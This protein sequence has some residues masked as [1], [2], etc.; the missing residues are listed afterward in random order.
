VTELQPPR[1]DPL[2]NL[3][4]ELGLRLADPGLGTRA[5]RLAEKHAADEQLALAAMLKLAEES[6][7]ALAETLATPERGQ[8]LVFCLG[9]SELVGTELGLAGPGWG[10]LFESACQESADSLLSQMRCDLAGFGDRGEATRALAAFKRAMFFR[11][12]VSD[13]THRIDVT[14]TMAAMSRLADE[15]IRAAF[16]A[17]RRS[18]GELARSAGDFCVLGMGKLGA[19]ELNLSSD[20]DL[21]YIFDA[22]ASSDGY[23]AAARIG[24]IMTEML[25]TG[26]FRVDL[27]LR[28]GGRNSPLVIPFGGALS[29]Y[30]NMGQTWERAALLRARPVAGALD[31]GNRL[32][33][34]LRAF[35]YRRYLDFDTLRQLRAM[36]RQVEA[37]LRSLDLLRRNIKLGYG[38]IRELEFIVQALT[39]IYGGRDPRIRARRT[40][41]ALDRLASFGYLPE[42]RAKRLARAY[43]FLRDV[44]HKLQVVA[45]L[46]THT[47]PEDEAGVGALAARLDLGKGGRA[48]ARFKATLQGHRGLVAAQFRQTLAGGGEET[49]PEVSEA[50]R[51][52]WSAAL[53]PATAAA[54]LK[55][56]GFASDAES[57]AQLEFLARGPEH[58][59]ASPRRTELLS[60]LGP[61]LL[62]EISA[63]ADP[64][65][66]LRNLAALIAAVGA[67]T[68]FLALLEQHPTTRRVLLRLFASSS[69]LSG[70]FIRHPD[71]LDTLVR[72][73]LARTRRSRA[74]LEAEFSGLVGASA[75]FEA[76]LDAIRALRHQEFLRIAI[77]DLAGELTPDEVATELTLLAEAVLCES[78]RLARSEVEARFQIPAELAFCCVAMGRLGAREMS[79]NSDLDLIFVYQGEGTGVGLTGREAAAHIAQ[80]LIA[81]LE[82]RTRE[83]YVYKLDLRLRPSGN[84][85]PLVTSF[86]G[87]RDYHRQ[88]SAVWERQALV[89]ARVVGG[90]PALA[91][92]VEQARREFVFGRGLSRAEVREIAA[93]RAR[94][95]RELGAEDGERLNLKNGRGG[96]VDV[97][98]VAQMMALAHGF[99]H[100]ELRKRS[101]LDLIRALAA[102]RLL[103]RREAKHLLDG[104]QFLSRLENRLRIESDQA[105]WALPTAPQA[106]GPV[107]R[108]MGYRTR[109]ATGRLLADLKRRREAIRGAFESCFARE[110]A[111]AI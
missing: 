110:L 17:A 13:L 14:Q 6:P 50:A 86:E 69:Y 99:T 90:T 73:D 74:E 12:A 24:E 111:R 60:R 68:S 59:P 89:R 85:G 72:S 46:Q 44:E 45:G 34:E 16:G 108:R 87:F 65:L 21:V 36:K 92:Q 93:M 88:S 37:E 41:D 75:D 79:Y 107:A 67:R 11:V 52:A 39:L 22:P 15:C 95:E 101:T 100:P 102:L 40:I 98:F 3:A 8:A 81:I 29:F 58:A 77:A 48:V 47:I 66:A 96:L 30:Q 26:C 33:D 76:R 31:L 7:V 64:D 70:L 10:E 56:L 83:G 105:A 27:R 32:L 42:E 109:D 51:A 28:P 2:E 97:E 84:Q 71:M 1:R 23:A 49:T 9:A 61:V 4:R 18:V 53:E 43:L 62:D 82:T 80:K 94:M 63:L 103:R 25:A 78:L 38:G 35:V 20:V 54:V 5:L 57:A 91:E 106:L 104:Y 19:K 55:A